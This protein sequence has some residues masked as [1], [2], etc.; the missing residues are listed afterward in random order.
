MDVY[1]TTG[2]EPPSLGNSPELK[3]GKAIIAQQKMGDRGSFVYTDNLNKSIEY[4]GEILVDLIPRIYDTERVI[5][6]LN[7]DGTS[8]EVKIGQG[9]AEF[10]QTIVDRQTGNKEIVYDLS[11]GKYDVVISTGPAFATQ[12][13][14]SAQQLIDLTAAN[15]TFAALATDLIAKNLDILE[16]DELSKRVRKQMIQQ[17]IVTPTDE[18]TEELGLDQPQQ[19]SASEVALLENVQMQTEKM[20]AEIENI[21][22]KN[23]KLRSD[24]TKQNSDINKQTIDA[25]SSMLDNFAA[26]MQTGIP[27]SARDHDNR[28]KQTDLISESQQVLDEGPNSEQAADL[29][30]LIQQ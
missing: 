15:P 22:A 4:T 19:P 8:E 1:S 11:R 16:S 7:I 2:L 18:E 12:R 26:Q 29:A 23:E 28:V 14:E 6:V 24:I 20:M 9:L 25:M 3:S 13:Q 27:L 21:D 30:Q 10:N 5:R 17:G